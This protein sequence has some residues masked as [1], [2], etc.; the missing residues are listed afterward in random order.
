MAN[1]IVCWVGWIGHLTSFEAA[2]RKHALAFST[3]LGGRG[4]TARLG[5]DRIAC[6]HGSDPSAAYV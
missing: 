1:F 6:R 4:R 2:A 3:D 5:A